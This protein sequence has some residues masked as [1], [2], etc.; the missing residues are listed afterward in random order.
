VFVL[1][2][3]VT[4][5]FA[6]IHGHWRLT[7][8]YA[9]ELKLNW[10]NW[11]L[12]VHPWYRTYHFYIDISILA[13]GKWLH[14]VRPSVRT[15]R[16]PFYEVLRNLARF[17]L[18]F[19]D[20]LKM[21]KKNTTDWFH[22]VRTDGWFSVHITLYCI[23]LHCIVLINCI[24]TERNVNSTACLFLN[25]AIGRLLYRSLFLVFDPTQVFSAS[26]VPRRTWLSRLN[27]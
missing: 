5:F 20:F 10:N 3:F 26:V 16:F 11:N 17:F 12:S 9:T 14:S 15:F 7:W 18:L 22:S 21:K 4:F 2:L 6:W 19:F 27:F 8:L 1:S 25:C 13:R 23:A 24:L